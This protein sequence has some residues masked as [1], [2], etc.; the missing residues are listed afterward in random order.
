MSG[1]TSIVNVN[2]SESLAEVLLS[3]SVTVY[4]HVLTLNAALG[5]PLILLLDSLCET[6]LGRE[7]V[8]VYDSVPLPP[9]A[10]GSATGAIAVFSSHIWFPTVPLNTG[11]VSGST[12]IVNSSVSESLAEVL[13]SESVTVYV[14]VVTD[15]TDL[16]VP[17][18]L[19]PDSL[20]ETPL[21]REHD[22]AYDS[23][24]LPPVA[25]GSGTGSI[26]EPSSHTWSGTVSLNSGAVS[27]ATTSIVNCSVSESLAAVLSSASVTFQV[28]VVFG[29]NLPGLPLILFVAEAND[30]PGGREHVNAYDSVP[31]PP[32][33]PGNVTGVI[34]PAFTQLWSGIVA[35]PNDGAMSGPTWIVR[36]GVAAP[37]VPGDLA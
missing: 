31:L 11:G 10:T 3:E 13:L 16:G 9:V 36:L 5:V 29:H 12:L 30:T 22:S 17:L 1:S 21:G 20:Y 7:H 34:R 19:L 2:V 23:V 14:H 33:A 27:G 37:K 6:P 25:P 4:V 18:I 15:N 8:N 35:F 28:H 32:V 26:A 24:P